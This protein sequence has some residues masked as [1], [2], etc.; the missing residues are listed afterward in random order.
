MII[1]NLSHKFYSRYG[2]TIDPSTFTAVINGVNVF[3]SFNPLPGTFE[4]V[5][6]PVQ[7][8]R[9]TL[10]F[11]VDGIVDGGRTATDR[12]RLVFIVS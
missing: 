5:S 8:G 12:D 9:N 7:D 3:Q 11:T 1:H 10:K 6:V 2:D 4:T